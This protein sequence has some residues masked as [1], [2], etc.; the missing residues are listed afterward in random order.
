MFTKPTREV[1]PVK[2][3]KG[4]GVPW[5]NQHGPG[6]QPAVTIYN[7]AEV[8]LQSPPRPEGHDGSE[9]TDELDSDETESRDAEIFDAPN[10]RRNYNLNDALETQFGRLLDLSLQ[11]LADVWPFYE[12]T[13]IGQLVM[14]DS[15]DEPV[16]PT[17][18]S[19]STESERETIRDHAKV[20]HIIG[21]V[22]EIW[23][24]TAGYDHLA[25]L[26]NQDK[27]IA[28]AIRLT[29]D[30]ATAHLFI[31]SILHDLVEYL[32]EPYEDTDEGQDATD[33]SDAQGASDLAERDQASDETF[34]DDD[35]AYMD[36]QVLPPP[37]TY[38]PLTRVE[39]EPAVIATPIDGTAIPDNQRVTAKDDK[40]G[41]SDPVKHEA[42]ME[43]DTPAPIKTK[44]KKNKRKKKPAV[45]ANNSQ[46]PGS[47]TYYD[48]D[49]DTQG[50]VE[51]PDA[52]NALQP[53]ESSVSQ[54]VSE[55]SGSEPTFRSPY[56]TANIFE[57]LGL[58]DDAHAS[59]G[60]QIG[61]SHVEDA[62]PAVADSTEKPK[63]NADRAKESAG[64]SAHSTQRQPTKLQEVKDPGHLTSEPV[65]SW[66]DS[67]VDPDPTAASDSAVPPAT[68]SKTPA[69][70]AVEDDVQPKCAGG[71]LFGRRNPQ[72]WNEPGRHVNQSPVNNVTN[73]RSTE[74]QSQ[75]DV[76]RVP[77]Q[78]GLQTEPPKTRLHTAGLSLRDIREGATVEP[79]PTKG[80]A[81]VI[82]REP[83]ERPDYDCT[84]FVAG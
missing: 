43:N 25:T 24:A 64:A 61:S 48:K 3:Y 29:G 31:Q 37:L 38:A 69:G 20:P 79:H 76:G 68:V 58:S 74:G 84:L 42:W 23:G 11:V 47:A 34:D 65:L 72:R 13:V 15:E 9:G 81:C 49:K 18:V 73:D 14:D 7:T 8:N 70:S 33:R 22:E 66:A 60:N 53:S 57:R 26:F 55:D 30:P 40:G 19:R 36:S 1:K 32:E 21:L 63:P 77:A 2:T 16:A 46:V 10:L 78:P 5:Q 44:S 45:R 39:I 4:N 67:E 51:F 50:T 83:L 52:V 41:K 71:H 17:D 28:T 62:Q 75:G 80:T 35:A 54:T 59:P 6:L 27:F 12:P 56:A 82:L